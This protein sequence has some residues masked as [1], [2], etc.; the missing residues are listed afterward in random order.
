MFITAG[1]AVVGFLLSGRQSRPA[2][3]PR[4]GSVVRQQ[5]CL[6][7]ID[8]GKFFAKMEMSCLLSGRW[9][10]GSSAAVSFG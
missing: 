7:D 8:F 6:N 10:E 5:L 1:E 3:L 2:S 9:L 4:S